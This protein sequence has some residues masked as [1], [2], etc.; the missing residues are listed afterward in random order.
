M[1]GFHRHATIYRFYRSTFTKEAI[2]DQKDQMFIGRLKFWPLLRDSRFSM[3]IRS[4][5]PSCIKFESL[6]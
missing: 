4:L 3:Q 5:L 6:S 1:G 2:E